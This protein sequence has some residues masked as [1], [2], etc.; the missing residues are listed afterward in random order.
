MTK[1]YKHEPLGK[2]S[3]YKTVNKK[4]DVKVL[5][6]SGLYEEKKGRPIETKL[7][8]ACFIIRIP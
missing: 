3:K 6:I 8:T 2:T 5:L 1:K 4:V 7:F